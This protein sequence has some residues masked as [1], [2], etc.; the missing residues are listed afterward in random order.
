[1]EKYLISIEDIKSQKLL[2]FFAQ[3]TFQNKAVDFKV[4]GIDGQLFEADEY[5]T[6]AVDGK[7]KVLAPDEL[8]HCLSHLA[9]LKDFINS[10]QD[11]AIILE[12]DAI[13]R[14]YINFDQL[15]LEINSMNL[16]SCFLLSLGGVQLETCNRVRGQYLDSTLLGQAVLQIDSDFLEH[17]STTYAYVVDQAMAKLLLQYHHSPRVY[18]CWKAL[19]GLKISFTFYATYLFDHAVIEQAKHLTDCK[20]THQSFNIESNTQSSYLRFWRKKLKTLF[21]KKY[22]R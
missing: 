4:L 16:S 1:M 13:E 9:A 19:A 12:D 2:C 20:Q 8:G 3:K 18:D 17:L 5:F 11:Y 10:G 14:F 7:T 21:L 22:P 6:L 15:E